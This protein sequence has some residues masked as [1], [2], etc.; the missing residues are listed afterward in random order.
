MGQ[1]KNTCIL[2]EWIMITY[3]AAAKIQWQEFDFK[4][5]WKDQS[6]SHKTYIDLNFNQ[7]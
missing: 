2:A 5:F 6:L 7:L 1:K 3:V 4:F